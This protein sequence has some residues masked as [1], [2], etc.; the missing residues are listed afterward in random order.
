MSLKDISVKT[1]KLK[2]NERS[3]VVFWVSPHF[4]PMYCVFKE[5]VGLVEEH[6]VNLSPG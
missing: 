2:I 6:S 4:S 1:T 3:F 5:L